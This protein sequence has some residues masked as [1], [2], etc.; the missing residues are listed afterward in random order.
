[1]TWWG[2]KW[3]NMQRPDRPARLALQRQLLV[4]D[5]RVSADPERHSGARGITTR[6]FG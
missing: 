1:M 3:E 2:V 4:G 6:S 5:R